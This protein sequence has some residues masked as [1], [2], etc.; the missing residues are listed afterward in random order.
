MRACVCVCVC[1]FIIN[2]CAYDMTYRY[3][4]QLCIPC[5]PC[6]GFSFLISP[7]PYLISSPKHSAN[8]CTGVTRICGHFLFE[9]EA[10][11][12][13][14]PDRYGGAVFKLLYS[15]LRAFYHLPDFSSLLPLA[16]VSSL[17][18]HDDVC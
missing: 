18:S 5:R 3:R 9:A 8:Y 11:R 13:G 12:N 7:S 15:H 1:V 14:P 10:A 16:F 6:K 17:T 2:V 4:V